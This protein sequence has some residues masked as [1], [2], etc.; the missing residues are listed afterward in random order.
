MK[1]ASPR[2]EKLYLFELMHTFP[3]KQR[4]QR[5]FTNTNGI[6]NESDCQTSIGTFYA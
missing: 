5:Q 2:A 3:K 4:P 6:V 1:H